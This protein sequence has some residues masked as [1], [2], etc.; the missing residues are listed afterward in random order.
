[1]SWSGCEESTWW[2][3]WAFRQD[4]TRQRVT[5]AMEA[6]APVKVIIG[7]IVSGLEPRVA[8]TVRAELEALPSATVL[9]IVEAWRLAAQGGKPFE[10]ISARP[11]SAMEAARSRRVRVV[12][13]VAEDGVHA[14]IS[15]VASRHPTWQLNAVQVEAPALV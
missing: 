14:E 9:S 6:H 15:H 1:M 7:E 5:A 2:I 4:E 10:V 12:I 11:A 8:D 13:D 3:S